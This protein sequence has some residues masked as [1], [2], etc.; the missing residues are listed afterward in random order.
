M[1]DWWY[2]SATPKATAIAIATSAART[3]GRGAASAH[4]PPRTAHTEPWVSLSLHD[5]GPSG[6]SGKVC[7]DS[8]VTAPMAASAA[9]AASARNHGG[10]GAAE[11]SGATSE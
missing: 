11:V 9:A 2:S 4:S 3:V 7:D 10:R 6:T 1:N 8:Q 5:H